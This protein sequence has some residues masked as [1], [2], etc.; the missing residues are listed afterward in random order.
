[1][2]AVVIDFSDGI[3]PL[4]HQRPRQQ[5]VINSV[6]SC[7]CY[8]CISKFDLF[9]H[10]H[11]N[12]ITRQSLSHGQMLCCGSTCVTIWCCR[13]YLHMF[14]SLHKKREISRMCQIAVNLRRKRFDDGALRLDQ[15]KLQ[16]SLNSETGLSC[17]YSVYQQKD[18]N[19]SVSVDWFNHDTGESWVIADHIGYRP[20]N[21]RDLLLAHSYSYILCCVSC[22]FLSVLLSFGFIFF[23]RWLG[24]N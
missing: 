23:T 4:S 1:M 2:P 20:L 19:R 8:Y 18:S 13:V 12:T 11:Q 24:A 16:F 14:K 17:G 5:I 7:W 3:I 22:C 21:N 10:L 6:F 9:P 15:V